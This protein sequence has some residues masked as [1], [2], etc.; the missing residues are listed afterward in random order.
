MATQIPEPY[1]VAYIDEAGDAGLKKVRP[2]D[3]VGATEWLC[4]GAV[5]I[6]VKYEPEVTTVPSGK[7]LEFRVA[8]SPVA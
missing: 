1:Y 6:K 3:A 5:L 7:W 2:I 8:H 4:L